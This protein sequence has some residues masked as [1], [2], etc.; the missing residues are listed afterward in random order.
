MP[1]NQPSLS[2]QIN[3][4]TTVESK[5][6][7]LTNELEQSLERLRGPAPAVTSVTKK[8][9]PPPMGQIERFSVKCDRIF[10]AIN[11]LNSIADE[12][13]QLTANEVSEAEVKEEAY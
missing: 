12:F 13:L 4:L 9:A 2:E 10:G 3:K 11:S 1:K 7:E 6:R 5:L 8:D